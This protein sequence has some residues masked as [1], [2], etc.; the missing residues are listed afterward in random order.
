MEHLL[1]AT[2]RSTHKLVKF[3]DSKVEDGTMQRTRFI[4]PGRR[5]LYKWLKGMLDVEDATTDH[6]PDSAEAGVACFSLGDAYHARK[7]PEHLPP[8][9]S[10]QQIGEKLRKSMEVLS[11]AEVAFGFRVAC[12][13][14]S[15][16]ILAYLQ[17]T[18]TFFIEQRLVWAMIMVAIGMT[19][20]TGA[21]TFGF[22]G[23]VFGTF[24]AMIVSLI[25]WYIAGGRGVPG[26]SLP[27]L[28]I[29]IFVEMYFFIKFPRFIV[30][31]VITVV[32]QV[33]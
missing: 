6:S 25:I 1:E 24:I 29:F 22:L 3:A 31:V 21:G 26:A 14:M 33:Q 20:T 18:Q 32:T 8:T 12:A 13:T 17:Q 10:T 28:W 15:I 4:F 5:R 19:M 11:Q 16:A 30:V 23:R 9:N 27:L 2:A 7:D